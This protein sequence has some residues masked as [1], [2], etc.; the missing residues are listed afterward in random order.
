MWP[1][2]EGHRPPWGNPG[3]HPP[4]H[5]GHPGWHPPPHGGHD[6]HHPGPHVSWISSGSGSV[7]PGAVW[8]GKDS[9]GGDIYVGRAS[10]EGDML[11]AKVAPRHGGAFVSWGGEEHSKFSYESTSP[12]SPNQLART[13][14]MIVDQSTSPLSPNQLARSCSM[15]VDQSTSPLTLSQLA[16]PFSLLHLTLF[17]LGFKPTSTTFTQLLISRGN[18]T[19]WFS[20]ALTSLGSDPHM[21]MFPTELSRPVG[22]VLESP[23]L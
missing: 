12:L 20:V 7:P 13:C 9:D 16:R 2:G 8:A 4:P 1:Q 10:H 19:F 15:I 14:S 18:T 17:L 11:P 23:C 3:W 22:P 21:A 6:Q 5:G